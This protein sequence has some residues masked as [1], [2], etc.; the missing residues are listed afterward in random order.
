MPLK[1]FLEMPAESEN[2]ADELKAARVIPMCEAGDPASNRD[3]TTMS[4]LPSSP[5]ILEWIMCSRLYEYLTTESILYPN[6][7]VFQTNHSTEQA[8][9]KLTNQIYESS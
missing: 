1:Y 2:F 9:V 8:I 4:V 5:K 6:Q 3:Y 7:F